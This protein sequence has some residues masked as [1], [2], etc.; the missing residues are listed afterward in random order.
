[1][2]EIPQQNV[3][4]IAAR[5]YACRHCCLASWCDRG[6]A[7]GPVADQLG[8]IVRHRV[9]LPRGTTL[10]HAGDPFGSVYIVYA[11]AI[12]TFTCSCEGD[13]QV[14]GFYLAGELVGMDGV[15]SG[16]H[17][18]SALALDRSSVCE[19]PFDRFEALAQRVPGLLHRMLCMMS[20]EILQDEEAMVLL[21][22]K[23]ADERLA[24]LLMN[25]ARR[26]QERG[27]SAREFHLPM[28]RDDIANY[29]GL[30]H[31]T[32]SRL[33]SRLQ[34]QGLLTVRGKYL[35]IN[36]FAQLEILAGST[37]TTAAEGHRSDV[38]I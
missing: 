4:D 13:E 37:G 22:K 33:F 27:Y 36:D 24:S 26:F 29:L 21:G 34:R 1:M 8:A 35:R 19:I 30:A 20:K 6:D 32:V 16:S 3:V 15:H 14:M 5:P 25:L 28:S 9:P 17:G 23:T 31:E 11:G 2:T 7:D 12:K 38:T 10:F 18:C